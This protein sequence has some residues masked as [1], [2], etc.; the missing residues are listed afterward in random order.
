MN[1]SETA[2]N[3]EF[4]FMRLRNMTAYGGRY[5]QSNGAFDE[6]TLSLRHE[7]RIVRER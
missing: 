7:N 3:T 4:Q 6:N 5:S 2:D 1:D